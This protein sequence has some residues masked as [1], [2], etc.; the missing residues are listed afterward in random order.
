MTRFLAI[1]F[2]E[3]RIGLA[4]SATDRLCLPL[5][6]LSR[7]NDR[8]AVA[9]ILATAEREEAEHLVVGEPLNVDGSSGPA[10]RRARSF[11]GR[12]GRAG[13][14]PVSLHQETLTTVAARE[15]LREAGVDLRR[16]PER[17]DAVSAQLL[18]EDFLE[19]RSRFP[20]ADSGLGDSRTAQ[21]IK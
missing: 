14:L 7:R 19:H 10:A 18:L 16:E 5:T 11:A 1:D 9:E 4:V 15:R 17:L 20:A 3:R 13:D 21:R 2:G 12:L 8:E 6:T